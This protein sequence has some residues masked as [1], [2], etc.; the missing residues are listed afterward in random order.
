MS[1]RL[2]LL[3]VWILVVVFA[4]FTISCMIAQRLQAQ[5]AVQPTPP[6]DAIADAQTPRATPTT[7]P[8]QQLTDHDKSPAFDASKA[9]PLSPAFKSQPKEGRNSGF[10]FYRDPLN[11]DK[12]FTT[13]QEV[14]Q[15]D[16]AHDGRCL[17]LEDT[18]E[19]FNLVCSLKLTGEEKKDL[20]AFL[21]QL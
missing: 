7:R 15:K 3:K 17:T 2:S 21:L 1:G 5:Q 10:D 6:H 11:S 12:P 20:V 8:E 16:V 14:Y 13:F 9:M 19:F 18:V 4:F